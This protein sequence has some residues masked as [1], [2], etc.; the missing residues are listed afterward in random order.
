[1]TFSIKHY[2]VTIINNKKEVSGRMLMAVKDDEQ[3][4]ERAAYLVTKYYGSSRSYSVCEIKLDLSD[5]EDRV[6]IFF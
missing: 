3:Y 5:E 6:L 4:D 2:I 1:M